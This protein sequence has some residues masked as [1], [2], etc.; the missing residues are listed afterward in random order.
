[1]GRGEAGG[2]AWVAVECC[3]SGPGVGLGGR[4][5]SVT[6][7]REAGCLFESRGGGW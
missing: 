1:M 4:L 2:G 7:I 5:E 3:E 6:N